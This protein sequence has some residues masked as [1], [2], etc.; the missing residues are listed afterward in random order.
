[1]LLFVVVAH[2][3]AQK[4]NKIPRKLRGVY[5]GIQ[6]A[7]TYR[8]DGKDIHF[9]QISM[10]IRVEKYSVSLCYADLNYC[11]V[12]KSLD[13]SLKRGQK[14]NNKSYWMLVPQAG[15]F[16]KEEW[17]FNLFKKELVRKGISPQPDT[18]LT[19]SRKIK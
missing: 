15:S 16:L 8:N 2:A 4:V 6:P 13:Y 10:E 14:P 7:Y 12:E 18:H 5:T 11:P 9:S 17:N 3:N 19:R 1:M